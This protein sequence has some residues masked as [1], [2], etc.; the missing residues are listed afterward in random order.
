MKAKYVASL[1]AAI[2]KW[3]DE[4]SEELASEGDACWWYPG[5]VSDMATAA[6]A[7]YDASSKGQD[8]AI[9]QSA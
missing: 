2:Q 7:I 4:N 3:A 1:E 5:M 8:F 9:E 6:A